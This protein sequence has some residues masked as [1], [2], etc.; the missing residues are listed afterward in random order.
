MENVNKYNTLS[1]RITFQQ[2]IIIVIK[3]NK[4]NMLSVDFTVTRKQ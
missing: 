1:P 3:V 2:L 4:T